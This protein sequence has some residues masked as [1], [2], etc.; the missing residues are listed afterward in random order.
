MRD[1]KRG[2]NAYKRN[3]AGVE[4]DGSLPEAPVF[5]KRERSSLPGRMDGKS[6]DAAV[7]TASPGPVGRSGGAK[8]PDGFIKESAPHTKGY[9]KAASLLLLLGKERAAEVMSHFS[10]REVEGIIHEIAL[11]KQVEPEEARKILSEFSGMAAGADTVSRNGGVDTAR[12][13]L[14][15]AFGAERGKELFHKYLPFGGETPFA[16]LNDLEYHQIASLLKGESPRVLSLVLSYLSPQKASRILEEMPAADRRDAVKRMAR[17]EKVDAEVIRTMEDIFRERLRTQGKVT[18]QELDGVNALAGILKFMDP[19]REEDILQGLE[20]ENPLL[21][22]NI[23]ERIFT[24]QD[25]MRIQDAD[26]QEALRQE[27]DR[28]LAVIIK[29][30]APRI[31]EKILSNLSERRRTLIEEESEYIGAMKRSEVEDLS[32]EFLHRLREREEAG[33]LFIPRGEDEYI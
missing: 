16:F 32:K 15:E 10:P 24:V 23:R 6:A 13:M 28:D 30:K 22:E 18:T 21:S 4:D 31:R 1:N 14:E 5:N 11:I 29:G 2:I 12:T 19:S 9:R 27:E 3:L 17:R 25:I 20:E 8:G 26:L 33:L 7:R